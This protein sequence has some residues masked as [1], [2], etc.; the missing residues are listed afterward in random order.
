M[1]K[2]TKDKYFKKVCSR[3][4]FGHCGRKSCS[5]EHLKETCKDL[6]CD[7]P[8][9]VCNKRHP[10]LCF[11]F[12]NYSK[13]TFKNKCSYL[14]FD[15]VEELR[16]LKNELNAVREGKISKNF[17]EKAL[18]ASHENYRNSK[19]MKYDNEFIF[20]SNSVK[21]AEDKATNE[22]ENVI[23]KQ[24]KK[25]GEDDKDETRS[26]IKEAKVGVLHK[27]K[28]PTLPLHPK[29]KKPLTKVIRI[30]EG[31][32]G[33]V[34]HTFASDAKIESLMWKKFQFFM[35][36]NE[37]GKDYIIP[38][39]IILKQLPQTDILTLVKYDD[40][41]SRVNGHIKFFDLV[42]LESDT[43]GNSKGKCTHFNMS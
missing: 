3:N 22:N 16:S 18:I 17:E 2:S 23:N 25:C 27:H 7:K 1:T 9:E 8:K 29:I 13:C 19:M 15:V 42:Y 12:H 21:V 33:N 24:L 14:H 11:F 31:Y 26:A 10:I 5:L 43:D 41:E 32:P 37:D 34:Y 28:K 6:T 39:K 4:Y 38:L 40:E 36:V 20:V 30:Y 35:I